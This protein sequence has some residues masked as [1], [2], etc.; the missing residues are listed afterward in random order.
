LAKQRII[1]ALVGLGL[2]LLACAQ[3]PSLRLPSFASLRGTAVES[4]DV[5]I[6]PMPLKLIGAMLDDG[7]PDSAA[8]AKM[9]QGLKKVN[10]RSCRFD[11]DFRYP[12]ADIDALRSQLSGPAWSQLVKVRDRN[13]NEDVDIFVAIDQGRINGLAV[14]ASDPRELTIV[15]I[16]GSIDLKQVATLQRQLNLPDSGMEQLSNSAQ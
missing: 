11:A 7:D 1:A 2:P 12:Q 8:M 3:D 15:N 9:L 4:V 5:T 16:V 14:I 10:V 6:G 13:K